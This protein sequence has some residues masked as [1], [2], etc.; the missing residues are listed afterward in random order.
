MVT[1]LTA[2]LL[3]FFFLLFPPVEEKVPVNVEI[4]RE[5]FTETSARIDNPD[6]GLYSIYGFMITDAEEDY[7]ALIDEMIPDEGPTNLS[8]VQINLA[9]YADRELSPEGLRNIGNLFLAL[10]EKKNNLIVR[11]TYDWDGK[12][13]VTEP[14][15][16]EIITGHMDQLSGLL[17][18][19]Q[20]KIFVVQGLF[21]GN[22]GEMN[23]TRYGSTED[24]WKLTAA[25]MEATGE[26]TF[27]SVRTCVQWRRITGFHE[28]ELLMPGQV[29]R[30]GLYNDGIMGTATDCGGYHS[31]TA[32]DSDPNL[33]WS[34]EKE[35]EFQDHLCRYVPNGGE[36]ILSNPL[37]D[38]R[39]AVST[40]SKMHVSYLN[41]DY[42]REVL[43]KW[44]S[45]TVRDGVYQGL[46]G[47]SYIERHLGY[48]ILIQDAK[49]AYH[50]PRQRLILDLELKNVGFAPVYAEKDIILQIRN[51]DGE[52][53][54]SHRFEQDLRTLYGGSNAGDLMELHREI[55]LADWPEGEYTAY[56]SVRDKESGEMMILANEQSMTQYGYKIA[57]IR[58]S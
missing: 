11:F 43:D 53:V 35:L 18:A 5:E 40:L 46:D 31:G 49:V 2:I 48:R 7:K 38:F 23:N 33:A 52:P 58:R 54:Y 37:N 39:S 14:K 10:R 57:G 22:W 29:V 32:H 3:S 20:D 15:S 6:R 42:D 55:S 44:A 19:N 28:P 34:R 25:L 8:M 51:A 24:L 30:M 36:V 27:L 13:A 12:A 45:V 41:Y 4:I 9:N 26:S 16:I 1:G 17:R 50:G 21:T 56:L 47:L